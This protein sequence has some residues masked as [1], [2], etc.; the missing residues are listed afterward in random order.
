[1]VAVISGLVSATDVR[2]GVEDFLKENL[3]ARL[4]ARG[5]DWGV[6]LPPPVSWVRLPDFIE[7][8][9]HESPSVV[10]TSPGVVAEPSQGYGGGYDAAWVVRVF[11]VIRGQSYNEVADR[12]GHYC[13]VIRETLTNNVSGMGL[14]VSNARWMDETYSELDT[15]SARTIGAGSVA[16]QLNLSNV[17]MAS[18]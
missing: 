13:A 6:D 5:E 18:R 9:E 17:L 12:V 4:Q 11:C 14:P 1:M 7:M 16:V 2:R 15:D 8:G 3:P 10:V